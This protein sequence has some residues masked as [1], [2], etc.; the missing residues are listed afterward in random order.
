MKNENGGPAFPGLQ[1]TGQH[2][3]NQGWREKFPE[4]ANEMTELPPREMNGMSLRDWFAGQ[5]MPAL[6]T[7]AMAISTTG[8][9][10]I[11]DNEDAA[12]LAY[13]A[14]DALIKR[15]VDH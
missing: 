3:A 10:V 6:I 14:A 4:A 13:I 8:K 9:N 15:R 1:R 2:I 7:G 5:I 11:Q 12:D